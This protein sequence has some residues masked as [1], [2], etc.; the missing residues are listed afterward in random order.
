M[1]NKLGCW[2]FQTLFDMAHILWEQNFLILIFKVA[3]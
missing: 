2:V 1:K 3:I